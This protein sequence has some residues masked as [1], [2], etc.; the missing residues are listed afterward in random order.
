MATLTITNN[1][2]SPVLVQEL[3]ASVAA[4]GTLTTERTAADIQGMTSFLSSVEA[5][6]LS[7]TL[8]SDTN[9]EAVAVEG[10]ESMY[11]LGSPDAAGVATVHAGYAGDDADLNFPGPFTNPDVPRVVTATFNASWNGGDI[12]VVGTDQFGAAQSEV[13]PSNPAGTSATAAVF[14]T[15]TSATK[16]LVGASSTTTSLGTGTVLGIPTKMGGGAGHLL[17]ADGAGE[18]GTFDDVEASVDPTTAPNGS[19]AFIVLINHL[20]S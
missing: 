1:T 6:D 17:F 4:N 5:G 8:K 12:T 14:A 13:I 10:A 3:Y 16:E 9:A 15:V 11:L 19:V 7:Y 18:A 20:A 2:S